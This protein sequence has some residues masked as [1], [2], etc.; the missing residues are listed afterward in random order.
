MP[1][2]DR[3]ARGKLRQ[4]FARPADLKRQSTIGG[5]QLHLCVSLGLCA[6]CDVLSGGLPEAMV[7]GGDFVDLSTR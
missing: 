5:L 4:A 3:S 2:V 7:L 1:M 6:G